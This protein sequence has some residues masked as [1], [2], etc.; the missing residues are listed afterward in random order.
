MSAA[1]ERVP[2]AVALCDGLASPDE[3]SELTTICAALESALP[4]VSAAVVLDLCRYAE[5]GPEIALSAGATRLV[6]GACSGRVS[7]HDVQR[8]VRRAGLD[9]FAVELVRLPE[10]CVTRERSDGIIPRLTAAI[11]R[12]RAFP[13]T[14]PEQLRPRLLEGVAVSRRSLLTL[15]PFVYEPVAGVE[16]RRCSGPG[17]C[18]L[19]VSTC[20][21]NAL[22]AEEGRIVVDKRR[23]EGCGVCLTS[24]PA[25]A[26]SLPGASL[27]QY[28]AQLAAL[29]GANEP[30]VLFYCTKTAA[31]LD[32]STRGWLPVEVPCIGM[33]TPG[34]LLQT[35][36]CGAT[37]VGFT[38]CGGDC[39]AFEETVLEGRVAYVRDLLRLLGDDAAEYRVGAVPVGPLGVEPPPRLPPFMRPDV[40]ACP[41]SLA[42]PAATATALVRLGQGDHST[43]LHLPGDGASPLGLVHLRTEACTACGA[44]AAACPTGALRFEERDEGVVL[45][46]D[47]TACN[48]CGRCALNC[49]ESAGRV[50][51]VERAADLDALRRGR[52]PL[53]MEPLAPCNGCGRPIAPSAMLDRIRSL[54]APDEPAGPLFSILGGLCTDCRGSTSSTDGPSRLASGHEPAIP[55]T[56]GKGEQ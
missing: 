3:Q 46:Y 39:R 34:W 42:E 29:L 43:A 47:A 56:R 7:P 45:S 16:H 26:V 44:C 52:T 49:P 10:G 14:A 41:P 53:K 40:P 25:G 33:V 22:A 48:G 12:A 54:V 5:R 23:C 11:A 21:F 6:V 55:G 37:A 15:P 19:C 17:A 9:P 30:A 4:G 28:E 13:G 1:R 51:R 8:R 20:P 24:C 18:G 27:S 32:G 2:V 35:V 36:A 50:L 31:V 38:S